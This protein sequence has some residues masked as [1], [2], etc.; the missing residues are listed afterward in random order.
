MVPQA[1]YAGGARMRYN[2]MPGQVARGILNLL[3]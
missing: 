1:S 3:F 2:P